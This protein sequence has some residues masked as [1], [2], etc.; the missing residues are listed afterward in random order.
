MRPKV[1]NLTL[2][3]QHPC[4]AKQSSKTNDAVLERLRL[5]PAIIRI[6]GFGSSACSHHASYCLFTHFDFIR[7]LRFLCPE[8][9]PGVC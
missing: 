9:V 2:E 8:D 5:H 3:A 6:A 4:I 1:T 7:C